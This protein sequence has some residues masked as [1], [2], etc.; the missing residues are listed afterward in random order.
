MFGL[1]GDKHR[2]HVGCRSAKLAQCS[3][4]GA[5]WL[6]SPPPH[7]QPLRCRHGSDLHDGLGSTRILRVVASIPANHAS[8]RRSRTLMIDGM[9]V[10][11]RMFRRIDQ[12]EAAEATDGPVGGDRRGRLFFRH[13]GT[14]KAGPLALQ[15]PLP[16]RG[17]GA[18]LA[19]L[20]AESH[21]RA[22]R[23]AFSLTA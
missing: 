8:L 23:L 9:P 19:G 22:V 20:G 17:G 13:G 18:E 1:V 4:R 11:L 10:N 2:K 3:S 14:F 6:F 21:A 12:G 5:R 15:Q 7:R 16:Q